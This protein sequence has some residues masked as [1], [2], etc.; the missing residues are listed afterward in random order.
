VRRLGHG[1]GVGKR[2]EQRL[3]QELVVEP[4]V[5]AF[6]EAVLLLLA[7]RNASQHRSR[8]PSRDRV[9]VELRPV[10]A[11]D[12][13]RRVAPADDV[14]QLTRDPEA[15]ERGVGDELPSIP[16]RSRQPWE[17]PKLPSLK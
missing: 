3:V 4:A 1:A 9:R 13:G 14:V 17:D 10:V 5:E 6:D 12:R 15:E 7:R 2:A 16:V 11:D 8:P